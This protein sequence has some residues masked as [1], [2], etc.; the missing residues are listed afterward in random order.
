MIDPN[1]HRQLVRS[2]IDDPEHLLR[3][4]MFAS[5]VIHVG[6]PVSS[7]AV[8]AE[9][10]VREGDGTMSVW[11]TKDNHHFVKRTVKTGLQQDGWTQ[12]L[13]GLAAGRDRRHGWRGVPEQQALV[14]RCRLSR[15]YW[16][17]QD[18][19]VSVDQVPATVRS[20]AP[21]DHRAGC[22]GVLR[23]RARCVFKAEHRGLSQS[24]AGHPGDHRAG[25]RV[26]PPRKWKNTT[27][28]RW[29]SASIRRRASTTSAR[30]RSTAC[31]SFASPSNTASTF[32]S[33]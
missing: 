3:S 23:R 19:A 16:L 6:D 28:S 11:A 25:G 12:I 26:F 31:R 33:R 9:G 29:R 22:R 18:T 21:R 14:G 1:T 24:G 13:T 4:G 15:R 27:R 8:P 17:T 32:T 7:L 30:P 2:E 10:V 20:D 5:F